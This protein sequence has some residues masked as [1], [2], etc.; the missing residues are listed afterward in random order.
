MTVSEMPQERL[1]ELPETYKGMREFPIDQARLI[2]EGHRKNGEILD[3]PDNRSWPLVRI[4]GRDIPD[5]RDGWFEM[6][7][8]ARTYNESPVIDYNIPE[9]ARENPG[10]LR[11]KFARIKAYLDSPRVAEHP[12][13]VVVDSE[14]ADLTSIEK[15]SHR[16]A[17][18]LDVG[19][20]DEGELFSVLEGGDGE[21]GYHRIQPRRGKVLGGLYR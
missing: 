9:M 13:W 19:V 6:L 3:F 1:I 2:L 21:L 18:L 17:R 7:L 11:E 14:P 10:D 4:V 15:G 8:L 12:Y 5:G 20:T 16:L